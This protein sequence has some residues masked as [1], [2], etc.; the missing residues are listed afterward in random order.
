MPNFYQASIQNETKSRLFLRDKLE[1]KNT[2]FELGPPTRDD[3]VNLQPQYVN[4]QTTCAN[5]LTIVIILRKL[6]ESGIV[7]DPSF[8]PSI[9]KKNSKK[10]QTAVTLHQTKQGF[11]FFFYSELNRNTHTHSA[12]TQNNYVLTVKVLFISPIGICWVRIEEMP[13]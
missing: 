3:T 2:T 1:K 6:E 7:S 11:F 4:H 5:M 10:R 9:L 12:Y 13:C 8:H